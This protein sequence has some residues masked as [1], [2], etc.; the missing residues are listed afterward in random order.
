MEWRGVRK[1][2][3]AWASAKGAVC[4]GEQ[5]TS[6]IQQPTSKWDGAAERYCANCNSTS[7]A[8]WCDRVQPWLNDKELRA[9][10][11]IAPRRNFFMVG[12]GGIYWDVVV[13]C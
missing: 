3:A 2:G 5:P 10:P 11:E 6:N 13:G 7:S 9:A 12:F 4:K 8:T 1:V